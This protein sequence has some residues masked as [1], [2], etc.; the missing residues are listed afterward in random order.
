M[1]A[2]TQR[3]LLRPL[4]FAVLLGL[5][6]Q[7]LVH[8]ADADLSKAVMLVAKPELQDQLYGSTILVVAPVGEDR[9]MG[10]ILNRPSR[11]TLDQA[12]PD[13]GPAQKVIEPVYIGGPY[14]PQAIF[15]LV[16]RPDSPG[17][18]SLEVMPGLF[19]AFDGDT[20]DR[21]IQSE[22]DHAR[23]VAGA[24]A[25]DAG[26]LRDEV[27]KGAW[28]VLEPDAGL[29]LRKPTEGLWEELVTRSKQTAN[30]I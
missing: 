6:P 27:E 9:H 21:I 29:A 5:F 2:M 16:Q 1:T 22:P 18:V 10:F 8:A 26:E 13:D 17:G 11:V 3:T 24:V 12:F 15:A 19:A 23:F 30:T 14:E 7:A 4:L 28:F 20:V 25:W